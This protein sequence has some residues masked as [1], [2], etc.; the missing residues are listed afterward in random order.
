MD[1]KYLATLFETWAHS[2]VARMPGL[3][4]LTSFTKVSPHAGAE[5]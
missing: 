3:S 1:G 5:F 2:Y 4:E